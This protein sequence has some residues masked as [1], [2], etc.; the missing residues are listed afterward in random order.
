MIDN[1][2]RVD[3]NG[4]DKEPHNKTIKRTVLEGIPLC[5]GGAF[6]ANPAFDST[7]MFLAVLELLESCVDHSGDI[8]YTKFDQK[9]YSVLPNIIVEFANESCHHSGFRLLRRCVRHVVDSRARD[10]IDT[11]VSLLQCE[12]H[13]MAIHLKN[14]IPASMKKIYMTQKSSL[15]RI[16]S[17]L[18][19][20]LANVV[21]KMIK[22]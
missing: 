10:I 21:R 18:V 11:E 2:Y 14:L 1:K 7:E 22:L 6:I 12:D 20:A 19:N 13:S 15:Q 9:V 8:K 3:Q 16:L 4:I 17:W 5:E